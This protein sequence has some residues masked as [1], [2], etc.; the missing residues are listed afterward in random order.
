[1][2]ELIKTIFKVDN[3][4][5]DP[6]Q[7]LATR[8]DPPPALNCVRRDNGYTLV[9]LHATGMHKETWEVTIERL[10][11]L[12]ASSQ[13]FFIQDIFSI[14]CPNHGESAVLNQEAL[15]K[16]FEN[17]WP[18]REYSRAAHAFLNAGR[19]RGAMVD[20]SKRTLIGIGHSSGVPALCLMRE[21]SPRIQFSAIIA[22]EP[23][24]S[25]MKTR[26]NPRAD[27]VRQV[28]SA[29]TWL[30]KDTWA[31]SDTARKELK[32]SQPQASWDPRI[33]NLYLKYA[34]RIHPAASFPPPFN[35][36]G[37]TTALTKEQEAASYRSD[38]LLDLGLEAY[39]IT[40]RE[41]PVHVVWATMS[42]VAKCLKIDLWADVLRLLL[43]L[44]VLDI[45]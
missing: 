10:Y 4:P 38:D 35:F 37:L 42:E 28:M 5:A 19:S 27:V 26:N 18:T 39:S 23:G 7:V 32:A 2:S 29:W 14:E 16:Y 8:Y 13:N 34:L 40:T 12:A 9:F 21:Y 1:M 17:N 15:K 30:K 44:K 33:L 43:G 24:L 3:R 20:F 11:K 45:W 25:E 6:L 22:I 36:N 41:I 31:S